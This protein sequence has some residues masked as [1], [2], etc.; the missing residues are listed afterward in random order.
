[1]KTIQYIWW[2]IF[3]GYK[4]YL[5]VILDL[6]TELNPYFK[7]PYI[8]WELLLPSYQ[9]QYENLT[10]EQ[11]ELYLNQSIE[12]WLKWVKNFCNEEKM[13]LV[14]SE[15]DLKKIWNIPEYKDTCVDYEI[16][17]YL[18]Y[19]Y[20]FYAK[21]PLESVK[22]YKIASASKNAPPWVK[23]MTAIMQWK[24]WDREKA[25]FMFLSLAS[26][27]WKDDEICEMVSQKFYD[28]WTEVF[29]GN[30]ELSWN[31][32]K[33]IS[34]IRDE[35]FPKDVEWNIANTSCADY[36]NKSTRELN[37]EYI[38][39]ADKKYFE[40]NGEHSATAKQLFDEW[41]M[42]YLPIDFQQ[43]DDYQMIYLYKEELW[44][45]DYN[46]GNY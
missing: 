30:I 33:N 12:L 35:V 32:I 29:S 7:N 39:R 44:H 31:L 10:L 5:F 11:Q 37:L 43:Y 26:S 38:E 27:L 14:E 19:I 42:D 36:I 16:P 25:Y 45:Y 23:L 15:I 41:Y 4:E 24:G 13:K 46:L 20:W 18:A 2:N 40:K 8:I 22:Y 17:F 28:I 6:I 34:E 3:T 1:L 9:P 21:N